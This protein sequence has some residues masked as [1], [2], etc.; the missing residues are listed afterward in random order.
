MYA[1]NL[2]EFDSEMRKSNKLTPLAIKSAKKPGLYG[3]GN[4]L[5]LQ[6]SK[7]GTKAWLFRFMRD[8]SARK[9][10]LGPLHTVSLADARQRAADARRKLLDGIDPI[11]HRD[12]QRAA[13]KLEAA[14]AMTF[15]Q[16]AEKYIAAHSGSWR[17]E[18]HRAQWG[19]T[20]KTYVY[21]IIGAL[22][23][24]AID[25]GL[26]LKVIEPIWAEKPDTAGRVRGRIEAVLSWATV[27]EYRAGDNPARWRGHL[28][29]VLPK[30]SKVRAVKHHEALPYVEIPAF[31]AM[32]RDQNFISARALEFVILT[33][34]RT[35]ETIGAEWSEFD[36]ASKIWTIPG[37]RMK[38]GKDHRV[39]L[40]DRALAILD[41]LPREGKFVFAGRKK[42]KP[43]SN[44]A[45]LELVRGVNGGGLTVHGFRSTFRDWAADRTSYA[46]HVVERALAHTVKD[47]VEKAY[48]RG[49]LFE[50]R[51]RLMAEWAGFCE[52]PMSPAENVVSLRGT[53]NA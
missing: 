41:A 52:S 44:M 11:A 28:D 19:S 50:K 27:R 53:A 29:N 25:T 6:I 8:G 4:G 20:L 47:A 13:A 14:K 45:M 12:T 3:D 46:N 31:M 2:P 40:S 24:A 43:L 23:V 16:C 15:E 30:R 33:A 22:P 10:G 48:R 18:K 36:L 7:F 21:P 32:L 37:V 49:D 38:S 9:M 5:Y 42:D 26:V 51:A 17:N 1:L 35:S 39:P 34:T